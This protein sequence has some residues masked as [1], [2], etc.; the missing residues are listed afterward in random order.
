MVGL[1]EVA[2]TMLLLLDDNNNKNA[3]VEK[4]RDSA[5]LPLVRFLC[6]SRCC[7]VPIVVG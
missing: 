4:T 7:I 1:T 3:T 6:E 2:L 5:L